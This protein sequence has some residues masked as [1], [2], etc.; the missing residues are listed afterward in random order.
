MVQ[1]KPLAAWRRA[2]VP[3]SILAAGVA[4]FA[5]LYASK[6]PPAQQERTRL[7]PL[8]E[9]MT[10]RSLQR[11]MTI[12]VDGVVVPLREI[13]VAAEVSGR[14]VYKNP[15]C[16]AGRYVAAGTPLLTIDP[17]RYRL[18]LDRLTAELQQV[19]A[20]LEQLDVEQ[21][22]LDAQIQIVDRSLLLARNEWQRLVPLAADGKV[23]Q[24]QLEAAE[25]RM[26]S[27]ENA[28][29]ELRNAAALIPTR[30]ARLQAQQALVEARRQQ[31]ELD[32]RR[33]EVTAP[34][35][36]LIRSDA[37][38]AGDFVQPGAPLVTIDDASAME[39][40]CHL[41]L[42]DLYWLWV[43]YG[44]TIEQAARQ[45][46]PSATSGNPGDSEAVYFECPPSPAVVALPLGGERYSW[47][48]RLVR[49]EGTGVDERTRTIAC[50]VR[51]DDPRRTLGSGPPAL[52]RGMYVHVQLTADRIPQGTLMVVPS[53]ALQPRDITVATSD[54]RSTWRI[55]SVQGDR[56]REHPVRLARVTR[57]DAWLMAQGL[58]LAEGMELVLLPPAEA[59]DGMAVRTQRNAPSAGPDVRAVPALP[60]GSA[61]FSPSDAATDATVRPAGSPPD[62]PAAR[63][64]RAA[65]TPTGPP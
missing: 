49:Y 12:E 36:G 39:V 3:L 23:T 17:S 19:Q 22:N 10:L 26:L 58:N 7:P 15:S 59:H 57:G 52:V 9:T 14:I 62:S 51:V 21:R 63:S 42:E 28:L 20:D 13:N 16:R 31:A 41:R 34:V 1:D 4:A 55:W 32:L 6:E 61:S 8:V 60:T 45:Q 54:D 64:A 38:E 25:A 46:A 33:T 5:L 18:E 48:G 30:R 29:Q 2:L 40:R 53:A 35:S 43:G 24:T 37:V 44:A 65:N 50:R 56:L 47:T 11:P 27:S